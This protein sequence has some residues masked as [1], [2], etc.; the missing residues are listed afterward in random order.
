MHNSARLFI[1]KRLTGILVEIITV[2]GLYA[3]SHVSVPTEKPAIA[4]GPLDTA[5][6]YLQRGDLYSEIRDYE[7]AIADYTQAIRLNPDYAEAYNNRGY[8]FAME[9]KGGMAKAIA[10]YSKAIQL[11]PDYA[12]AYNNRG[13]VYLAIGYPDEALLDFNHAIQLQPYFRQAFSNRGNAFLRKGQIVPAM[14]DFI[15]AGKFT[16]GM[17]VLFSAIFVLVFWIAIREILRL[18]KIEP[19]S[20]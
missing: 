6:A 20:E 5:E 7:S 14:A 18:R 11:R 13:V 16:P 4:I 10:D 19:T 17:I 15:R 9:G 8:T 1:M 3:C 2:M 12:Y